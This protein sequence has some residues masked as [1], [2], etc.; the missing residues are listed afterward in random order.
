M[1]PHRIVV[2]ML[3]GVLALL[4]ARVEASAAACPC[5]DEAETIVNVIDGE[6]CRYVKEVTREPAKGEFV[7]TANL[8]L[9]EGV[10]IA[11]VLQLLSHPS[12]FTCSF[13]GVT[14]TGLTAAQYGA[15]LSELLQAAQAADCTLEV[16]P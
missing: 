13:R 2:V 16:A 14:M 8:I 5:Y 12:S 4:L 7:F 11:H 1:T 9:V 10:V 3:M 6:A 15:C